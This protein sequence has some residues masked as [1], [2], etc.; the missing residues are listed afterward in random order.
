MAPALWKAVPL[1]WTHSTQHLFNAT[2]RGTIKAQEPTVGVQRQMLW[3]SIYLFLIGCW[4]H[5]LNF[6]KNSIFI[7]QIQ[8]FQNKSQQGNMTRGQAWYLKQTSSFFP[9]HLCTGGGKSTYTN[10]HMCTQVCSPVS[11][12]RDLPL[13]SSAYFLG[14]GFHLSR[15]LCIPAVSLVSPRI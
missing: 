15:W 2:A 5:I 4:G 11:A 1:K 8:K 3:S 7:Q 10:V 6:K 9:S 14:Q 12:Y 13:L